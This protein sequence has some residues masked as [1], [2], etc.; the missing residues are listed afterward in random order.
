MTN[1]FLTS[2]AA[3]HRAFDL[4][5]PVEMRSPLRGQKWYPFTERST[6][7]LRAFLAQGY[8]FRIAPTDVEV[9][10]VDR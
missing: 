1:I 6:L 9:R 5:N 3:I 7:E 10:N 4:G 8:R 2:T